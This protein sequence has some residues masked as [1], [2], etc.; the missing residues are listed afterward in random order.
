[1]KKQE[2]DLKII[3]ITNLKRKNGARQI[4]FSEGAIQ[5]MKIRHTL[6]SSLP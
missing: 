2:W 5:I 4:V 6:I 1:M 3:P